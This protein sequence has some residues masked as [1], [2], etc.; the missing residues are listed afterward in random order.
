MTCA[1]MDGCSTAAATAGAGFIDSA[2]TT[3]AASTTRGA[4]AAAGFACSAATAT[5]AGFSAGLSSI[6]GGVVG[7]SATSGFAAICS[8]TGSATGCGLDTG[9]SSGAVAI[10][11]AGGADSLVV[12]T[13]GGST[14]SDGCGT[15]CSTGASASSDAGLGCGDSGEIATATGGGAGVGTCGFDAGSVGVTISPG[16][17]GAS[18]RDFTVISAGASRGAGALAISGVDASGDGATGAAATGRSCNGFSGARAICDGAAAVS[19]LATAG[20]S[21]SGLRGAR[22]TVDGIS[23]NAGVSGG[24]CVTSVNGRIATSPG[25]TGTGAARL[26]SSTTIGKQS[27]LTGNDDCTSFSVTMPA[28]GSTFGSVTCTEQ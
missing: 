13:A 2:G 11:V 26:S 20:R 18:A 5:G 27:L 7:T 3:G 21:C 23:D 8:L 6:T 22:A 10:T 14:F 16:C 19:A 28:S 9:T 12:A 1:G 17:G 24:T 15:D 4:I 25:A